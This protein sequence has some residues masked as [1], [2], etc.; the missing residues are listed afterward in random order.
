MTLKTDNFTGTDGQLLTARTDWSQRGSGTCRAVV[1]ASNQ[2]KS[3]GGGDGSTVCVDTGS[4]DMYAQCVGLSDFGTNDGWPLAVRVTDRNSYVAGRW[5]SVDSLWE[6][7][8]QFG[9]VTSA[10]GSFTSGDVIRLEIVSDVATLKKN[11]T[12]VLTDTVPSITASNYA[13]MFLRIAKDPVLDDWQSDSIGGADVTAPVLTTAVGTATG[14]TT[15]T[16]GA[17]TDE[18]NGTLRVVVTTSATQPSTVQIKAGQDHTGATAPYAGSQT[19]TSTGAKTF[20]ATGLTASTGYYAHNLHTD[21]A[22]NDS[23]RL[24]SSLFTTTTPDVTAPSFGAATLGFVTK[25]DTTVA[26]TTSA[27]ATDAVGVTGYEWSSDNGATYPFT[28]L[29]N[30]FTFSALTALTSYNFRVR[31]YDAAGNRSTALTLTTSTYRAGDTGQ[32]IV[33]DTVAIPGV[34]EQGILYNDVVLPGDATK[35]F[36]YNVTTPVV[37]TGSLTLYPNG[38]FIWT[39]LSAD[40]FYYQLEVDDANVGSPTLVTLTPSGS[41]AQTLTFTL[42]T[43]TNSFPAASVTNGP[44]DNAT[45]TLFTNTQTFFPF[46]VYRTGDL[47]ATGGGEQQLSMRLGMGL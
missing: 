16:V 41:G 13:G 42:F 12:T 40:S 11:G 21:T 7:H 26:L 37:D 17:T 39:G 29:S 2:I 34:Q 10:S 8:T 36:S 14:S 20:S 27:A 4:N 3:V 38:S 18:A 45:F 24:S 30:S 23:N 25:T 32:N 33:D 6:I 31:A 22:G 28:S 15:A 5:N 19:I 35:W 47:I 43:N 46:T 9:R 44:A 1:N